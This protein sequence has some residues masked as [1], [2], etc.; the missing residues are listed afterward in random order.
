[1]VWI[2][3]GILSTNAWTFPRSFTKEVSVS[4][5]WLWE[6]ALWQQMNE[7]T[8]F[9]IWHISGFYTFTYE[10]KT[11][12]SLDCHPFWWRHPSLTLWVTTCDLNGKLSF[13]AVFDYISNVFYI[14]YLYKLLRCDLNVKLRFA[15]VFDPKLISPPSCLHNHY[16]KLPW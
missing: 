14:L 1:M 3:G 10:E 7:D 4:N 8:S 13:A 2:D 16:I 9:L 15:A 5:T 12:G 6:L 11:W